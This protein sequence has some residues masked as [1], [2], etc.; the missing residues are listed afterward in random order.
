MYNTSHG[1]PDLFCE[2]QLIVVGNVLEMASKARGKDP[3]SNNFF[4]DLVQ[5][6]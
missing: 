1:G 5:I 2:T 3:I 4:F 6:T